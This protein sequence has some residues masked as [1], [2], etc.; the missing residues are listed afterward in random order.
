MMPGR[1]IPL[2][3]GGQV[4]KDESICPLSSCGSGGGQVLTGGVAD[5]RLF[6]RT[7][8]GIKMADVKAQEGKS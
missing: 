4:L 8:A 1:A 6:W 5:V 2:A 7:F 3:D